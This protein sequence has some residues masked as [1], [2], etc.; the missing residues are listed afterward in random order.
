MTLY[1]CQTTRYQISEARG[2]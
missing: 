1:Y 2:L